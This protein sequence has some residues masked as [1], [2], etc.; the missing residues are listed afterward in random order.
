MK[1]KRLKKWRGKQLELL[2]G[3][4]LKTLSKG[5]K[6]RGQRPNKI[7]FDDPQDYAD[8]ENPR[9]V[10]KFN[11]WAMSSLYNTLP[12]TG[13]MCVLGTIIGK[14]CF[15][16][17]LRDESGWKTIEYEAC[18]REFGNILWPE[19]WTKEKLEERLRKVGSAIFNQEYRNIPLDTDDAVIREEWIKTW[20]IL[21]E[22]F[23]FKI[24]AVDPKS[25]LK[26]KGD[27]MGVAIL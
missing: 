22:K 14:N 2:N 11:R 23:D 19:M 12:P 24:M 27:Y 8:V 3:C 13:S 25:S 20:T 26:Q 18:D 1:D 4:W 5:R 10:K 15:V 6:V 16:K 7:I 17:W 21:P 9:I